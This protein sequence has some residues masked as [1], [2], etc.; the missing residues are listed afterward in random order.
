MQGLVESSGAAEPSSF[1]FCFGSLNFWSISR[2]C[3]AKNYPYTQNKNSFFWESINEMKTKTVPYQWVQIFWREVNV[4]EKSSNNVIVFKQKHLQNVPT[5]IC[6]PKSSWYRYLYSMWY[7]HIF[8]IKT[9]PSV[10]IINFPQKHYYFAQKAFPLK[11]FGLIYHH[12]FVCVCMCMC[13]RKSL[14]FS[15]IGL[16]CKL[17]SRMMG[18]TTNFVRN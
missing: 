16:V 13:Q 17:S 15:Q 11:M 9:F 2:F 3:W 5:K 10:L 14:H 18:R 4:F 8:R 6:L 1:H 7:E 12:M